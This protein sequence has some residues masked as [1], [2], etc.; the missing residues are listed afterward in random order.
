[1][2]FSFVFLKNQGGEPRIALARAIHSLE[3]SGSR[4]ERDAR[5]YNV[6]LPSS[7]PLRMPCRVEAE[8]H[9]GVK[10]SWSYWNRLHVA[11]HLAVAAIS[12]A[13]AV[14]GAGGWASAACFFVLAQASVPACFAVET[15]LASRRVLRA[16]TVRA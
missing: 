12:V 13:Q 7:D 14:I 16:L 1:M 15:F 6:W 8:A 3:R 9:G 2:Q 5:G 10:F 4:A 11:L